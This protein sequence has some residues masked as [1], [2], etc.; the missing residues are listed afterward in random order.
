MEQKWNWNQNGQESLEIVLDI[1]NSSI[2][3]ASIKAIGCLDFLK[4]SQKMKE[5]LNG[6][7]A[8]LLPPSG[9]DHSSMIWREM[10]TRIQDEW[11][12]PV[13]AE[14]LCHC[15]KVSTHQVDRSIVYGAHTL[16]EVRKRTS[17]NTGCGT[18]K[19]D[20]EQLISYRFKI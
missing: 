11:Q 7:I 3:K 20:V 14:E 1:E 18:C 9:K 6:P 15:R 19:N 5:K 10:I 17:A 4:L 13:A 16:E 12:L 2:Q 8:E